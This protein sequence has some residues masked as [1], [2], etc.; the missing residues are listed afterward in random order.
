MFLVH[1]TCIDDNASVSVIC[2]NKK[3]LFKFE[4]FVFYKDKDEGFTAGRFITIDE[5][6]SRHKEIVKLLKKNR[7]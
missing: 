1:K 2:D 3:W 4:V 6:F 7:R 5:A